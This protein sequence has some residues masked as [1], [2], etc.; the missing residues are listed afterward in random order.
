MANISFKD[1]YCHDNGP[2]VDQEAGIKRCLNYAGILD[3]EFEDLFFLQFASGTYSDFNLEHAEGTWTIDTA[4]LQ[5]VGGGSA[6]WYKIAHCVAAPIGYVA[7]FDKTGDQGAFLLCQ[8]DDYTGYMVWWTGTAVGMSELSEGTPTTLVSVPIAETGAAAVKVMVWGQRYEK[9]DTVDDLTVALYFDDKL[10]LSHTFEYN[11]TYGEYTGF[12]VYESDTITI[13]N[14]RIAQ[15]HQVTGNIVSVDAGDAVSAGLSRV[16]AT[17]MIRTRARYDGTVHV[18]RN[19]STSSDWTVP[20]GRDLRAEFI[21]H[22]FWPTHIRVVG[23]LHEQ[24][25]VEDSNHGHIFAIA[26]EPDALTEDAVYSLAGRR[27]DLMEESA[28]KLVI[29]TSVQP[30]LEPEDVI[31]YASLTWRISAVSFKATTSDGAASILDSTI[32]A[33]RCQ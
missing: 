2:P 26:Q 11:D 24:D 1:F 19:T 6:Q 17:D 4:K 15:L 9:I 21:R 8:D 23:A 10:L 20:T 16:I 14:Y 27:H 3:T 22:I 32:E 29:Q 13:D 25:R 33:R 30:A 31:T 12:A 7:E 5:G 28:R 18:W